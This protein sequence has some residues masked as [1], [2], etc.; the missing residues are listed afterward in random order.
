MPLYSDNF[1]NGLYS[2]FWVRPVRT[3]SEWSSNR[4]VN[5]KNSWI[6]LCPNVYQKSGENCFKTRLLKK[7]KLL[8]LLFCALLWGSV[9]FKYRIKTTNRIPFREFNWKF[10]KLWE[11]YMNL[12]SNVIQSYHMIYTSIEESIEIKSS[13]HQ[14]QPS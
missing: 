12:V 8:L 9:L 5:K 11:Q 10:N 14:R 13:C 3:W 1:D 2:V 7:S 6:I 4:S